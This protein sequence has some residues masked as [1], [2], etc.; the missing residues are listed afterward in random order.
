M[1]TNSHDMLLPA[2]FLL[3]NIDITWYASIMRIRRPIPMNF[4]A[5]YIDRKLVKRF[6]SRVIIGT[7]FCGDASLTIALFL[8]FS[9]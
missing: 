8:E 2:T 9:N 6:L 4:M 5:N 7:P 3:A 1:L